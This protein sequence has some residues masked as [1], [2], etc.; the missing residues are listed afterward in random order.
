M[1]DVTGRELVPL[2]WAI[3]AMSRAFERVRNTDWHD[4]IGAFAAI[5]ETLWWIG[6]VRGGLDE[7]YPDAVDSLAAEDE[8]P[9][10]ELLDGL[11]FARNRIGHGV[12]EVRYVKASALDPSGFAARWTWERMERRPQNSD[13][14]YDAYQSVVA[15]GDVVESLLAVTVFLGQVASSKWHQL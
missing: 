3:S 1:T 11:Q 10:A 8:R 2:N 6:V 4:P 15:G 7:L 13:R 14:G 5:G 9:M 12:D